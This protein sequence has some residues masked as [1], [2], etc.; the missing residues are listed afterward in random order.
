[1]IIYKDAVHLACASFVGADAFLTCDD[2]L[3]RRAKRLKLETMVM[4]D[5][6]FERAREHWKE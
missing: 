4:N 3:I 6:I 2:S 1:M 5:E